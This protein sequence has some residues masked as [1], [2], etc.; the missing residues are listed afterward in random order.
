M[1]MTAASAIGRSAPA[2][3]CR[4]R[5]GRPCTPTAATSHPSASASPDANIEAGWDVS[6]GVA[7]Y[8]GGNARSCALNGKC[9]VPYMPVANNTNFLVEQGVSGVAN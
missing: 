9:W 6:F 4:Y 3:K 5:S 7:W 2:C 8:F 1:T